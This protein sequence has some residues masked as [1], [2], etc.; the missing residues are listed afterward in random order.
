MKFSRQ[1]RFGRI[2]TVTGVWRFTQVFLSVHFGPARVDAGFIF[3]RTG[4]DG[5]DREIPA[6]ADA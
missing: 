4:L 6:N 2:A 1:Q 5:A 3:V